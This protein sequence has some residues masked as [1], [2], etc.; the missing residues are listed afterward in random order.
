MKNNINFL[1]ELSVR[2]GVEFQPLY[3]KEAIAKGNLERVHKALIGGTEY[4]KLGS[5]NKAELEDIFKAV[6]CGRKADTDISF[7]GNN[8]YVKGNKYNVLDVIKGVKVSKLLDI[9]DG[10]R[11]DQRFRGI[12]E[13]LFDDSNRREYL[14]TVNGDFWTGYLAIEHYFRETEIKTDMEDLIDTWIEMADEM[15]EAEGVRV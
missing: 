8:V 1:T 7:R 4:N 9:L 14:K 6:A 15:A 13:W 11:K 2:Y 3:S 5:M 10:S 12:T